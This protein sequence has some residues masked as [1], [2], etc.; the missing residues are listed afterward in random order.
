MKVISYEMGKITRTYVPD[1]IRPTVGIYLPD[2]INRVAERYAFAIVPMVADAQKSGAQFQQGRLIAG[3]KQI[4]VPNLHVYNDGVLVS[5]FHT[6]MAEIVLEDI[7]RWL[8]ETF[9]LRAPRTPP[10]SFFESNLVIE[11]DAPIERVMKGF[12]RVKKAYESALLQ[13]YGHDIPVQFSQ[14]GMGPDPL[15]GSPLFKPDFG[16]ARRANRPYSENRYFS[17]APLPTNSHVKLLEAFE[18]AFSD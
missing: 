12:Q 18:A 8:M 1:E 13:A 16:I 5:C 7:T 15:G 2:L 11:F 3:D 10:K 6:E 4:N 17:L 14:I 9:A